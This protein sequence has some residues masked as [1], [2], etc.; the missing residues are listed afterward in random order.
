MTDQP[1]IAPII[2]EGM[3]PMCSSECPQYHSDADPNIHDRCKVT[4]EICGGHMI[5]VPAVLRMAE[6]LEKFDRI[7]PCG[8][9]VRGKADYPCDKCGSIEP[10]MSLVLAYIKQT[11]ELKAAEAAKKEGA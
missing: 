9:I 11:A 5:C 6:Q 4:D 8:A 2:E 3:P 10:G 7:C 1:P